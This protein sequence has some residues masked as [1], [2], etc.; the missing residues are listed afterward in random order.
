MA[1]VAAADPA[2]D[3]IAVS[4]RAEPA[5][6]RAIPIDRL[7]AEQDNLRVHRDAGVPLGQPRRPLALERLAAKERLRRAQLH[8]EAEPGRRSASSRRL[9]RSRRRSYSSTGYLSRVTLA[10]VRSW[11]TSGG[12]PRGNRGQPP[13]LAPGPSSPRAP[14]DWRPSSRRSHRGRE[15]GKDVIFCR[16]KLGA[17]PAVQATSAYAFSKRARFS[18]V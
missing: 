16:R 1:N 5:D 8:G 13:A 14:G 18:A 3:H 7:S 15:W 4:A 2:P 11:P 12:V 9:G 6:R 10:L 17:C